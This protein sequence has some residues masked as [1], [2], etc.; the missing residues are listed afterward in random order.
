M[1]TVHS[2]GKRE[3]EVQLVEAS[4]TTFSSSLAQ[5]TLKGNKKKLSACRFKLVIQMKHQ[6]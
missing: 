4:N 1:K 2:H 6:I 3:K 5:V